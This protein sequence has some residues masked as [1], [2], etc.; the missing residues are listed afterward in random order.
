MDLS[1]TIVDVPWNQTKPNQTNVETISDFPTYMYT[2]YFSLFL[3]TNVN[4]EIVLTSL[5]FES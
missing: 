1:T 2:S 3:F 5:I 4:F